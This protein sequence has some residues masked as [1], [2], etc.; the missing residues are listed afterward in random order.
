[1]PIATSQWLNPMIAK[2][3]SPKWKIRI[4]P[5]PSVRMKIARGSERPEN[6]SR[7]SIADIRMSAVPK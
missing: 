3:H 4:S 7:A 5:R 2:P 1:M 6:H